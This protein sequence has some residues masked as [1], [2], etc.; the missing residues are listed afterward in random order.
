MNNSDRT[1]KKSQLRITKPSEKVSTLM[2]EN[3][4][5]CGNIQRTTGRGMLAIKHVKETKTSKEKMGDKVERIPPERE[6]KKQNS[7]NEKT[8]NS[9]DHFQ[10]PLP[11]NK[12]SHKYTN[13]QLRT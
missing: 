5:K 11:Q 4:E 3:K 2:M 8:G 7:N 10:S 13:I 9:R 1:E 6:F 12:K